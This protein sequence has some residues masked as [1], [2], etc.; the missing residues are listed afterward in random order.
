MKFNSD[1]YINNKSYCYDNNLSNNNIKITSHNSNE[2]KKGL[3]TTRTANT[4]AYI[5]TNIV[6]NTNN[7]ITTPTKYIVD[8]ND[9]YHRSQ[10][11]SISRR[12]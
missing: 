4:N 12:F 8:S 1:K 7:N 5:D 6:I 3:S 11:S 2:S 10:N 9:R